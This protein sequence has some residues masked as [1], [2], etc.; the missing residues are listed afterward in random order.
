MSFAPI[1][2]SSLEIKIFSNNDEF[3][4]GSEGSKKDLRKAIKIEKDVF[5]HFYLSE[6]LIKTF[7]C[8]ATINV[9]YVLGMVLRRGCNLNYYCIDL[10]G[11]QLNSRLLT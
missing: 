8:G 6:I 2:K 4:I 9:L 5:A 11:A 7:K 3:L 10:L 1:I